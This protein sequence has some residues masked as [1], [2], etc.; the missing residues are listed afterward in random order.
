MAESAA[1]PAGLPQQEA[2]FRPALILMAGRLFGFLAAFAIPMVLARL[3]EP[4]EFGTYKQIF[5]IFGTLFVVAQAG[6]A[7]SLY[8]FLPSD[9]ERAGT[10]ICNTLLVLATL[11]VLSLVG[12]SLY[13]NELARLLNNPELGSYIPLVGLYLLFMLVAVVLEIV[14]TVRK[15]HLYASSAYGISDLSRALCYILPVLLIA[16]LKA[17]MIGAIA[18]ALARL[19]ATILYVTREYRTSLHADPGVL[20]IHLAYAIPFGAAAL[21]EVIQVNYHLYAV[22]YYFNAATFAIYAVGCLQIPISD[23]LMT[24]TCNVMM[25]NM[26]EKIKSGAYRE[27]VSIWLDSIRKLALI[28]FP[29]VAMLM[30]LAEPL[31]VFLFT[32]TYLESVPIFM[33]CTLSMLLA[34]FL[35]DGALRVF[36]QTHFLILQ[37]IV[38]LAIVVMFMPWFLEHYHLVGAITVTLLATLVS[39]ALALYRIKQVLGVGLEELLPWRAIVMTLS[40]A[41]LALIPA[42]MVITAIEAT[43]FWKLSVGAIVYLAGYHRLVMMIGPMADDEKAMLSRY[44]NRPINCLRSRISA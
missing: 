28:F 21:I 2:I 44:L 33:V 35:T 5:L 40:M 18:F 12:L 22:S 13:T 42:V 19:A 36:G 17:L 43:G 15:Q 32:D 41:A 10:Y 34:T 14:M 3:F 37:N 8:Y 9:C 39:K 11:G 26:Q 16:D 6:M 31:I 1:A 7:E 29:M 4:A 38:R 27:V 24:S 20:G 23:F 30:M 25:I